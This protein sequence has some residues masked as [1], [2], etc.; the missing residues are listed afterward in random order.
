ML[1]IIAAE[2]L[3]LVDAALPIHVNGQY[4]VNGKGRSGKY[5]RGSMVKKAT[6]ELT[7]SLRSAVDSGPRTTIVAFNPTRVIDGG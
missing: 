2:R 4:Q 6:R 1:L 7:I 5:I 3:S